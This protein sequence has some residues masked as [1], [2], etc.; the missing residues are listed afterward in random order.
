MGACR[1]VIFAIASGRLGSD[2]IDTFL[3][4][5]LVDMT[6]MILCISSLNETNL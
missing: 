5:I 1:N 6:E 3:I 2:N 4:D